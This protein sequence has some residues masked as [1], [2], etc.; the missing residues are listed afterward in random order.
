M[1][2]LT[3]INAD[4]LDAKPQKQ[5]QHQPT[6]TEVTCKQNPKAVAGLTYINGG[7]LDDQSIDSLHVGRSAQQVALYEG[8]LQAAPATQPLLQL[9]VAV[10]VCV[11]KLI[12]FIDP[13]LHKHDSQ[14][15]NQ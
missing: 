14:S 3:Y 2:G 11:C 12:H 15:I 1:A 8:Q 4:A 13:A 5:L 10:G 7:V 6:P 9:G